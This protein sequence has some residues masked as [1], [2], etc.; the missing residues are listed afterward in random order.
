MCDRNKRLS[1]VIDHEDAHCEADAPVE[2]E[3]QESIK[4]VR[5]MSEPGSMAIDDE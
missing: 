2:L 3:K 4:R 5:L 1:T